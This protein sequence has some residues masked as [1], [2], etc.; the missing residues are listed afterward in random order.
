MEGNFDFFF[1][2][3]A[4]SNADNICGIS[5]ADP[6]LKCSGSLGH[7]VAKYKSYISP[8]IKRQVERSRVNW[9]SCLTLRLKFSQKIRMPAIEMH[10]KVNC[11][12]EIQKALFT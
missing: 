5:Y 6:E 8:G 11:N 3:L 12:R 4:T 9:N 10:V 7:L 1:K 2:I